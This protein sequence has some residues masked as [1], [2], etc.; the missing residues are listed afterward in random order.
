MEALG[1]RLMRYASEALTSDA[2]AL[3]YVTRRHTSNVVVGYHSPGVGAVGG[4]QTMV[5][6]HSDT[7]L[8]TLIQYGSHGMSGLEVKDQ[9]TGEWLAVSKDDW[10]DG[11]LLLNIGDSLH[12][13]SNGRFLSTPHRVIDRTPEGGE[14]MIDSR[15]L[16]LPLQS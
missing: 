8:M 1:E 12:R 6:E 11:A 4:E 15:L 14:G 9:L 7:G 5:R 13:L 3:G 10:P 16:A 2:S